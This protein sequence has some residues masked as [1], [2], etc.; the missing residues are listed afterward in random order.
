MMK[1]SSFLNLDEAIPVLNA[2][3]YTP[4]GDLTVISICM[5]MF[6]ILMQTYSHRNRNFG[7]ALETLVLCAASALTNVIY[8]IN[9]IALPDNVIFFYL[10]RIVHHVILALVPF[11]Y[12]L[13]LQ[14]PLWANAANSK[15]H[16]KFS[17]LL[18]LT[19]VII[20]VVG[21][22]LHFTAWIDET[23]HA[24]TGVNPYIPLCG[25]FN[26]AIFV[27]LIRFR[28][29][30]IHQAFWGMFAPIALSVFMLIM[31]GIHGQTSFTCATY[32]FPVLGMIFLFH[33]NPYDID[34]GAVDESYFYD[35]L[36]DKLNKKRTMILVSC[37]MMNFNKIIKE[38]QT[39]KL[40]FYQFFRQDVQRGVLY[41][42]PNDRM[43]LVFEKKFSL[44]QDK[45]F[46]H[47][48]E[49]FKAGHEKFKMDYKIVIM[50]TTPEITSSREYIRILDFVEEDML[51]NTV[52]E[53]REDDI[54]H[55]Y[56]DSYILTQLEDIVK[57]YDL[58][59]ERI[60]VYC[61]PVFN[62]TTGTYDTAEALMRLKLPNVGMVFP[63]QFIPLAEQNDLIHVMSLIILNKTCGAVRTLMEDGYY[64]NRI[65][66]NFSTLD[67][68][69]ENFCQDVQQIIAR[70]QIP[71]EKIAIE[72]TESR[73][74]SDFNL[75]K[76]KVMELQ[77]LG[78]KFYLD[79]FGTG[80]SNF[81]R[82][83][84]IPFD[85]IK[86]DRSMLIES[87]KSD[88]AFYMVSTFANMFDKLHYSVLFE[89][90]ETE[91]DEKSCVRM[92]AKY[93]QGYKYSKPIPIEQLEN[94]LTL[95]AS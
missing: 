51:N 63:D 34:T 44:N 16:M 3:R 42:F 79:D 25:V 69:Y 49:D 89:G 92:C 70:N 56:K 61:Q 71:Y 10:S 76:Q 13:Y 29:R 55:F 86:F 17:L 59:D 19:A 12:L 46:N 90:I 93:L 53:V 64:V 45:I 74:E 88:S 81:D 39:V 6:I 1:F 84:E 38:S 78:I 33:S 27:V 18:I 30:M 28:S 50:E 94:F 52:H 37:T 40:E 62:I 15:R 48:L 58:E 41:H 32:L 9:L 26:L 73:N 14:I 31:Q 60:L 67:I 5:L 66:V 8:Q 85:I 75:M 43:M 24:I 47:M 22:F 21:M 91:I 87:G 77:K 2:G 20:D 80:Y 68:R 82:I 23:G 7:L 57:N 11:F 54:K 95:E 83:M 65:S 4:V 72:I 35:E 36:D